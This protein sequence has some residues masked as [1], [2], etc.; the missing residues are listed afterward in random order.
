MSVRNLEALF[1]PTSMVLIGASDRP[2]SLGSVV[3]RNLKGGGF[4]GP[5][6]PVN[7][8]HDTVD[9]ERA[10]SDIESLPH[11]RPGRDLHAAA[12]R[13]GTGRPVGS[14]GHARRRRA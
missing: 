6:W 1:Q 4:K 5:L 12:D 3:L 2:G 10:W 9:G 11:A 14:Q 8:R 7:S 13:A